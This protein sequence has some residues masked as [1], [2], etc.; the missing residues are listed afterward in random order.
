M[1]MD[2]TFLSLID[3]IKEGDFSCLSEE[4]L[5]ILQKNMILIEDDSDIYRTIKLERSVSRLD[6]SYLSLTIAPT[7]ACNFKCIYC[8]ESGIAPQ[9]ITNS[10]QLIDDTIAFI[11]MFI[12][13][14]YLRVTWYGGEPLLQFGY[15]EQLSHRLIDLFDN[16]Q[17]HM[18]TNAYLLDKSKSEKLK[19]LRISAIQVTID[20]LEEVNN[21]RRPH[22]TNNDSFQ[23]I[24]SNLDDLF[25]VYP[26]ISIGFRVN[27]D[28][29]NQDEYSK[30]HNY[31]KNRYGQYKIN[32]HPGYVTDEFSKESNNC[33]FEK[34]EAN[35]FVLKQY[36][37]HNIPIALYP[38]SSFGECSARHI[39]SFV[40][41][42][43]GE[44]YKCWNDLGIKNKAVG[45]L[46][47]VSLSNGLLLKYLLENDPLSDAK[48][49]DCFCFPICEG[50]CPYKRIYQHDKQEAYCR[51]RRC[52][53]V[54]KLRR[55]ID[56]KQN[57]LN[58]SNS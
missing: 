20:G 34:E 25:S 15:I 26:E 17:A 54:D 57:N 46:R 30:I 27:V 48:C 1:K 41:G 44:L 23:K 33:C 39:T 42:P 50:G 13:T 21:N 14:K 45:T 12:N 56:Y 51:A 53:I 32:I 10:A 40:I 3:K 36:D 7:T 6:T 22:K 38:R 16:Y 19:N 29:S 35:M 24:I 49:K 2:A 31:L 43:E 18:I 11:K 55:Y 8:Y 58:S 47:E 4:T 9:S 5:S 28:K 52:A 37:F